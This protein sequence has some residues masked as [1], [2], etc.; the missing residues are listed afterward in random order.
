MTV[1][2]VFNIS[3]MGSDSSEP[4]KPAFAKSNREQKGV[5]KPKSFD[6]LGFTHIC[7]IR[8]DNGKFKLMRESIKKKL[9]DK[10]KQIGN[11]LMQYRHK[12][13]WEL[14]GWLRK[15]LTGC[16]NY[17]AIPGNHTSLQMMRTEVARA[18]IKA[19]RR[20]SQK[21]RNF[22]WFKMQRWITRFSPHTRVR[23]PYPNQRFHL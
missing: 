23:H 1:S 3:M 13:L 19:M 18:W 15:V 17:F 8:R 11:T 10:I 21:G 20:R 6:F 7:S 2:W 22:N 4:Q 9:R 12:P 14:G 5:G 16:Y